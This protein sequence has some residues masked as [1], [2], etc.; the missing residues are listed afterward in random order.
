MSS[1]YVFSAMGLYPEIPGVAGFAIGSPLFSSIT[2]HLGNGN[3]LQIAGQGAAEDAPYVQSLALNGQ[4]FANSWLP[5]H[6]IMN[7]ATLQFTL[8]TAPGL[9]ALTSA[10]NQSINGG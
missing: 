1:W 4:P 3:L 7:G 6:S 9:G 2:V 5:F 8:G 10:V